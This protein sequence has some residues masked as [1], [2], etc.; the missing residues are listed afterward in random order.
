[1]SEFYL[2]QLF[3]YNCTIIYEQYNT[4]T[5]TWIDPI[6]ITFVLSLFIY[7]MPT[8]LRKNSPNNTNVATLNPQAPMKVEI[9]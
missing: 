4:E 8:H 9:C 1:M 7:T 2:M 5:Y 6:L 3:K